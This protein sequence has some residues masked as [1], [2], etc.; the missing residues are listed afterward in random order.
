MKTGPGCR[1]SEWFAFHVSSVSDAKFTP[2]AT[3]VPG[4]VNTV[5]PPGTGT[6][7]TCTVDEAVS[8]THIDVYKR[9]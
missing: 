1:R 7:A 5:K 2:L 9:Q 3:A 6:F 8:Y 4:L